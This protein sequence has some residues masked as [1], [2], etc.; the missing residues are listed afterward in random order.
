MTRSSHYRSVLLA[1]FVSTA[2]LAAQYGTE[3]TEVLVDPVGPNA[4]AQVVELTNQEFLPVDLSG[5]FLVTSAGSYALPA[6]VLPAQGVAQLHLGQSGTSTP[7]DLFLPSVPPLASVDSLALFRSAATTNPADLVDFV[8][9]GGGQTSI[10][11]AVQAGQW[12]SPQDTVP[13]PG[14]QGCTIGHFDRVNYGSRDRAAAWFFDCTPTLGARNDGGGIFAGGY[15]CPGLSYPPQIGSGEE[16]NRPWIGEPWELDVGY[17]PATAG[18]IFVAF[19]LTDLGN[20]PLDPFGVPGCFFDVQPITVMTRFM[21]PLVGVILTSVPNDPG[22]VGLEFLLQ[23]LVPF[24]GSNA[25]NMLPT[26][27]IHAHVGSR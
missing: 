20:L 9:W 21:P 5:W 24:P 12:P 6:S 18:P 13:L 25:A 26:R 23:G 14:Q 17:L 15:G 27:V 11:V 3:F 7:T 10:V 4:G 22:F 1:V 2:P 8:A 19:G 16:D